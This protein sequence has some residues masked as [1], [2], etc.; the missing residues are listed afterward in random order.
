LVGGDDVVLGGEFSFESVLASFESLVLCTLDG[1]RSFE[2]GGPSIEL[3]LENVSASTLNSGISGEEG[4]TL[5]K[6]NE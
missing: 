1:E 3:M 2:V 5:C 4:A 6:S